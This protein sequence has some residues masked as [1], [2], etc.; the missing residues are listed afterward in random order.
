MAENAT[1]PGAQC[2]ASA[3]KSGP[4][5]FFLYFWEN[6]DHDRFTI[7]GNS[8]ITELKLI[9]TAKNRS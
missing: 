6:R 1:M 9:K 3:L 2:V 5:R 7:K 8:Q 4:V